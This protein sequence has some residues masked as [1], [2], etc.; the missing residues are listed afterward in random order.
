MPGAGQVEG[1]QEPANTYEL[2]AKLLEEFGASRFRRKSAK[3]PPGRRGL[4]YSGKLIPQMRWELQ[5]LRAARRGG[6][7][8]RVEE[9]VRDLEA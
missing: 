2:A 8:R 1:L 7:A 3:I 9:I 4:S 5:E 6:A